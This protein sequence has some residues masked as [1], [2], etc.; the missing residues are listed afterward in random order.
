MSPHGR[1]GATFK[2]SIVTSRSS[3]S[4][5]KPGAAHL[6][7]IKPSERGRA[8]ALRR[9]Q[10]YGLLAASGIFNVLKGSALYDELDV[11]TRELLPI[12]QRLTRAGVKGDVPG[13]QQLEKRFLYHPAPP[14]GLLNR[15]DEL[16]DLFHA[17][18]NLQTIQFRYRQGSTYNARFVTVDAHPLRPR[19]RSRRHCMHRA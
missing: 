3:R 2:S 10:A 14:R 1:C 11:V 17:V 4:K 5:P 8:I 15:G 16:D 7:R 9:T 18:A 6:W 12:A 19:A 13:N